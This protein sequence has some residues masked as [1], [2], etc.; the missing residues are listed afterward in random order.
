MSKEEISEAEVTI[1]RWG[2][3]ILTPILVGG[4]L[5]II[6]YLAHVNTTLAE[7]NGAHVV[8]DASNGDLKTAVKDVQSQQ[9]QILDQQKT[10][11][12]NVKKIET[13]QDHFKQQ[14]TDLK[15]QN[16]EILYILR[17]EQNGNRR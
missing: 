6:T 12:I 17:K 13:H 4:F 14:I 10:I 7:L 3:K 8:Y 2:E 1:I 5:G 9:K 15:A 16:A 11:E